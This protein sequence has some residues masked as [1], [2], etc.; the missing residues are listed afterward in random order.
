MPSTVADL[1][2]A[3]GLAPAAPVVWGTTVAEQRAGVYVVALSKSAETPTGTFSA[4]PLAEPALEEILAVR[5]ELR[6]DG[7][8]PTLRDLALRLQALWLP[9]EVVLYVGLAGTSLR[10][11]VRQYYVTPL[12]ARRPHAGGWPLKTLGV[13]PQLWVYFAACPAPDLA[14]ERMLDVFQAN[15]SAASRAQLHDPALPLPFANLEAEK[16]RRKAHGI[17][18]AREPRTTGATSRVDPLGAAYAGSQRQV[19]LYVNERRD[20]LDAALRVV[21]A[22]L[23]D[24]TFDW[25]SP[26]A[27]DRYAEYL[28]GAFLERVGIA[29]HRDALRAFWPAGGRTG[30]HSLSFAVAAGE[31]EFSWSRRKAIQT[32]CTVAELPRASARARD[33]GL[34]A[35]SRGRRVASA[36]TQPATGAGLCTSTRTG[37]PTLNG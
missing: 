3:A 10:S 2:M 34:S 35:R 11:R 30:M 22:D 28:D 14:E 4:C 23:H 7:A 33:Y 16:G 1:F 21:F 13:L 6:I 17:K 12:G 36:W 29:E 24:A 26:L 9:D 20:E 31:R 15:V 27:E 19:Q 25:R 37:L 18:G 8:R 32:S 5:P